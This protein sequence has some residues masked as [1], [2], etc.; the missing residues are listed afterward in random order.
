[1]PERKGD[2]KKAKRIEENVVVDGNIVTAKAVGYVDLALELGKIFKIYK[3]EADYQETV[4]V[5]RNYKDIE[6]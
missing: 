2:F 3:D 5:Y 1:M 6:E 4:E